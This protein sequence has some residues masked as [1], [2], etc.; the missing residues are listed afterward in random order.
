L[1][2]PTI[3]ADGDTVKCKLSFWKYTISNIFKIPYIIFELLR[4]LGQIAQSRMRRYF[5]PLLLYLNTVK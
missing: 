4:P 3:D 2:I 5:M 1:S